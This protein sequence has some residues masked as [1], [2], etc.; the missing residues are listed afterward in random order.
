MF[1]EQH[2]KLKQAHAKDASPS[3]GAYGSRPGSP[4]HG[5]ALA[6]Q[7]QQHPLASSTSAATHGGPGVNATGAPLD[8]LAFFDRAKRILEARDTYDP[9]LK[10]LDLFS[11][12]VIDA[13]TL[14]QRAEAFFGDGELYAQFK[15]LMGWDERRDG[16]V[17]NGDVG[18][19]DGPPGSV[20]TSWTMDWASRAGVGPEAEERC[21]KSY[22]RLPLQVSLCSCTVCL[23]TNI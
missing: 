1:V 7:H 10:L 2:K 21:G 8:E 5:A 3:F 16:N 15:E 17:G 13:K 14:I 23:C 12:E 20:R 4:S 9:F 6:Q 22:R 18:V 11:R 19:D